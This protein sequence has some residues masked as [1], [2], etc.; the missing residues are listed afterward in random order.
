MVRVK[1]GCDVGHRSGC[2]KALQAGLILSG[3]V[4][5]FETK[6]LGGDDYIIKEFNIPVLRVGQ[7]SLNRARVSL[8]I[9][10]PLFAAMGRQKSGGCNFSDVVARSLKN[11]ITI[12]IWCG[13]NANTQND[14]V[15]HLPIIDGI[16]RE[17]IGR[18]D[19]LYGLASLD[20]CSRHGAL[21]VNAL[22]SRRSSSGHRERPDLLGEDGGPRRVTGTGAHS[23]R[24]RM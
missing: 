20:V 4:F 2:S 17:G 3:T 21:V 22:P 1:A 9:C 11:K 7:P 8:S 23:R 18:I 10:E 19:L 12:V 14:L 6:S 24:L 16:A 15:R 5:T 13:Q